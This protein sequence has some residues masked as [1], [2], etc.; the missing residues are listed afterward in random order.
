MD[1]MVDAYLDNN[2]GDDLMI[3]LLVNRF[4]DERFFLYTD[5]SVVAHTFE[6]FENIVI[7][8]PGDWKEDMKR[9]SAYVSIGGSRFQVFNWN[10]R[11]WRLRR[12]AKLR[13][14]RRHG[15]KIATIG[16]N[17]G[18][19]SDAWGARLTKWELQKNDLITVRDQ[20][21]MTYLRS[22]RG[23]KNFHYAED[24][25]YNL[26]RGA[27][28]PSGVRSGLGI[29]A[30]RSIRPHE[31]NDGNY[32]FLARLADD[33]IQKTGKRVYLFAFD[34][35]AEND[36]AAAHHI[37][38]RARE[39]EGIVIVPYLG[40]Q[41]AFL[42]AFARCDRMIAIRFHSAVL[43]DLYQIPFLPVIYSNKMRNFL[44]DR[45]Y[46]GPALSLGAM[47]LDLDPGLWTDTLIQGSKLFNQFKADRLS[48]ALHFDQLEKMFRGIRDSQ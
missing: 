22:F 4:P 39:K 7:R 2:L 30:Y 35:E 5:K 20:E 11:I 41:A 28:D 18:P 32:E 16:A 47:T 23:V 13:K 38:Q 29:S 36:L 46:E 40:G 42:E 48:A 9:A 10:Q 12:I 43:A 21:A 15:V 1:I 37:Y 3:S 6:A 31:V 45:H 27:E 34:T 25:V 8:K 33:Y 26:D 19:Y 24:I 44:D 17:L 14:L